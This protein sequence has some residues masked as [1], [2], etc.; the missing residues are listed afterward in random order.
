MG[1]LEHAGFRVK[2]RLTGLTT[3][4]RDR[5]TVVVPGVAALSADM[6]VAILRSAGLSYTELLRSAPGSGPRASSL[7]GARKSSAPPA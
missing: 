1:A 4:A 6:L 7:R 5:R 3:L 2:H